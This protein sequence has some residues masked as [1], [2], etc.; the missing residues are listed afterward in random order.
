MRCY[1]TNMSNYCS[2]PEQWFQMY[3]IIL[4]LNGVWNQCNMQAQTT[5]KVS[6]ASVNGARWRR[7][8][9][10]LCDNGGGSADR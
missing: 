1:A 9:A 4:E 7:F 6:K 10:L 5:L 8:R 3:E 2:E